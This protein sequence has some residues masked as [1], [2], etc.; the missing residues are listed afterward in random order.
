MILRA[1]AATGWLAGLAAGAGL[2]ALAALLLFRPGGSGPAT[3][4]DLPLAP[5][6]RAD[7]PARIVAFGTSLTARE[8]WPEAL[9][10]RLEACLGHPV[11]LIRVARN[12]AGSDWALGQTGAVIAAR[13]DLVLIEFAVNDADL[14]DGARLAVSRAKHAADPRRARRRAARGAGDAD[15]DESGRGTGPADPAPVSRR[16]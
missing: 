1:R 16:L 7:A 6:D 14:L 11:E 5:F 8:G 4:A 15:D 13:P 12:G 3:P 10:A 2:L 9:A